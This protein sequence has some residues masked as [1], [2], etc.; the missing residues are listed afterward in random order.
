MARGASATV[1][2][3]LH[4]ETLDPQLLVSLVL[5]LGAHLLIIAMIVAV[6]YTGHRVADR[7]KAYRVGLVTLENGSPLL[8]VG[9]LGHPGS[10]TRAN[11]PPVTKP[12]PA[13]VAK[14]KP[15][16]VAKPKPAPVAKP[17]PA[18]VAKPKPAPVAKP[19]P[20][21][22]AKPKPTPVAKPKPAP[23]AK[24]KPAPAPVAKTEPK[25]APKVAA[26]PEPKPEPKVEATPA[27][28]PEPKVEAKPEPK[29]E[30]KIE[31]KPAPKPE[32]K[33]EP[34]VEAKPTPTAE[35]KLVAQPSPAAAAALAPPPPAAGS[36][37][38]PAQVASATPPGLADGGSMP[39]DRGGDGGGAPLGTPWGAT[40]GQVRGVEF[41]TYYNLM[42]ARIKSNWV[43]AGRPDPRL[44]V[45]VGFSIRPD[46]RIASVKPVASS[47]NYQFDLSVVK[48]VKSVRDLGPPPQRHQ[49]EFGDVQIVFRPSDLA[50]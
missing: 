43:W 2:R 16:P 29:P 14:P 39:T 12:Q 4:R 11:I 40:D 49:R 33:I 48:A 44:E 47:G 19:T 30:P 8:N 46:G 9:P 21:P 31:A 3:L 26:K 34:T 38:A 20:T 36:A 24:P 5:S 42:L 23:V 25:P 28:K 22:V 17:K 50:R 32:P 10:A 35:P 7:G 27:P 13:R 37:A 41:M 18:P 45:T 1:P 6:G 15:A